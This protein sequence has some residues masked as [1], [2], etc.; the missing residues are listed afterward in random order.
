MYSKLPRNCISVS[1]TL[2]SKTC[3][4][5][6][7]A[8]HR[9]IISQQRRAERYRI[10]YTWQVLEGNVPNCGI[11]SK[12]NDREEANAR[13][14]LQEVP[15]EYRIWAP[16]LPDGW[17]PAVI[18][19]ILRDLK[20]ITIEEFKEKLDQFLATLPDHPQI[21]DMVPNIYKQGT[22]KPSKSLIDVIYT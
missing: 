22:A 20:K 19:P 10:L 8:N 6:N 15:Q 2:I 14:L 11:Q 18:H 21:G 5:N 12:F 13:P 3:S 16:K 1:Y 17:T 9:W 7:K 4:S